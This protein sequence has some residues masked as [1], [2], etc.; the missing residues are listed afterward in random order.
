V[1]KQ[2]ARG[3]YQELW[4]DAKNAMQ[5]PEAIAVD[6]HSPY[7]SGH[8]RRS[9]PGLLPELLPVLYAGRLGRCSNDP[10]LAKRDSDSYRPSYVHVDLHDLYRSSQTQSVS[11][12]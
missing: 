12:G 11:T 6:W 4:E 3:R 5:A 2:P 9:P 1:N 8:A 7:W 10:G